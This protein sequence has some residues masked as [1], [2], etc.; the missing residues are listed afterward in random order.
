MRVSLTSVFVDNQEA[1]LTFYT[2][3][4]GFVTKVDEP[5]GEHR[6]ITVVSPEDPDGVQLLLEPAAHPAAPP[7][8]EALAADGIPVAQFSVDN[9]QAEYHRLGALGVKFTQR[10]TDMGAVMTAVFDD[11]CGNLIQIIAPTQ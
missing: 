8:R 1:A 2:E 3:T 4:L 11:T 5:V 7:F 10:P 6:W 9:V